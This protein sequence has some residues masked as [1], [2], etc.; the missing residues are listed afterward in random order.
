MC[1]TQNDLLCLL[2]YHLCNCVWIRWMMRDFSENKH[3]RSFS[4]HSLQCILIWC[5]LI[6]NFL[7]SCTYSHHPKASSSTILFILVLLKLQTDP[8]LHAFSVPS[9]LASPSAPRA[10]GH[11]GPAAQE[12]DHR[13]SESPR[14]LHRLPGS[15]CVGQHHASNYAP[16][17]ARPSSV[18]EERTQTG[19]QGTARGVLCMCAV[20][21]NIT[22][23]S[24]VCVSVRG[25]PECF[26]APCVFQRRQTPECPH[27]R[28]PPMDRWVPPHPWFLPVTSTNHMMSPD[29]FCLCAAQLT[30]ALYV[31]VFLRVSVCVCEQTRELRATLGP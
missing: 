19:Q 29:V 14:G 8:A 25:R 30:R 10:E 9:V 5:I 3:T 27:L 24:C 13:A 7:L 23:V 4:H 12:R 28:C 16:R 11:Q 1:Q 21:P 22:D 2:Y 15:W 6:L 18:Q 31:C 20:I 26:R 17:P